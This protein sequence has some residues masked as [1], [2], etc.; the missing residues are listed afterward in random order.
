MRNF[1]ALIFVHFVAIGCNTTAEQKKQ[2]EN[3]Q[4]ATLMSYNKN[5]DAEPHYKRNI[6]DTLTADGWAIEY[7]V[8]NDSTK[9]KDLYIQ[10]SKGNCKR[11]Y[12]GN[13]LLELQSYFTPVFKTE[14]V[15]YIFMDFE[16]RGGNGV[17]IL[18]KNNTASEVSF[19]YVIGYNPEYA[20]VA[21]IPKSSYSLDHLDVEAYDLKSGKTK[22][23]RFSHPCSVT[24]ENECVTEVKFDK[25]QIQIL[26][27][28][29]SDRNST[30][31]KTISF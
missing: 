24:P 28:P 29:N 23:V 2:S 18:P 1:L 6:K 14:T 22:S 15:N 11:V 12:R 19:S 21:Y 10:W 30:E 20:Q 25:K 3:L 27:N 16:V 17:L 31:I 4:Y 7:L 8:R 13:H 5:D 9:Q 26:A